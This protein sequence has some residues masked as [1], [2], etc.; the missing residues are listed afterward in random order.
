MYLLQIIY[1]SFYHKDDL[2]LLHLIVYKLWIYNLTIL[3]ISLSFNLVKSN[4]LST[5]E[6][7]LILSIIGIKIIDKIANIEI[8]ERP[9][10]TDK[11]ATSEISK[12]YLQIF[13]LFML[14]FFI[15]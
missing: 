11:I 13:N 1:L 8:N 9:V 7:C 3:L 5:F 15:A 2:F 4:L 14:Y 12:M 6:L 10:G